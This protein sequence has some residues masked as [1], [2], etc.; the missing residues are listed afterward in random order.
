MFKILEYFNQKDEIDSGGAEVH[1]YNLEVYRKKYDMYE[2]KEY[3][4]RSPFTVNNTNHF[5]S[6]KRCLKILEE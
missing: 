4:E 6:E 3:D 2:E 1:H 5:N